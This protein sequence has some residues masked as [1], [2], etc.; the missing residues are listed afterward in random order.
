MKS[1][2]AHLAA[3]WKFVLLPALAKMGIWGA[4]VVAIFDSSSIPVPI[5]AF[6]ALWFWNDRSHFWIF[7][8]LAAAGSALGGLVPY[9]IGRA[10]GELF[11]LQRFNRE[12]IEKIRNRFERQEFLAVLIPSLLPPPMPWKIFVFAAGVFEMPVPRFLLAVFCG[13]MVRWF[14]LA[15]LVIEL[16]P[17][18]VDLVARHSVAAIIIAISLVQLGILV[19]W[20]RKKRGSQQAEE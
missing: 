7:V 9:W 1:F 14:T 3:K 18:A 16:G 19:W 13:R 12:R 4:F 2:F 8:V 20:M 5:D 10:G 11:L 15:I 6:L 17:S